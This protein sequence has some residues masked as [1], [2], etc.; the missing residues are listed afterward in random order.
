MSKEEFFN[1]ISRYLL[2]AVIMLSPVFFVGQA[3]AA[4]LFFEASSLKIEPGSS[5]TVKA[6]VNTQN[7]FINNAEAVIHYPA[8]LLE[9]LSINST[10]TIFS[11]WVEAPAF[12]N[13]SGVLSFNGGV[14][15]PG[16]NGGA[17]QILSVVFKAKKA[18]T[19]SLYFSG[20][21][22]R[23]NDGLGTDVLSGQGSL[24]IKISDLSP[25][26]VEEKKE[27]SV[28]PIVVN[29]EPIKEVVVEK[30]LAPLPIFS[31]TNPDQNVWY[32]TK[33]V[34]LFWDLPSN[35]QGIQMIVGSKAEAV[36]NEKIDLANKQK[37]ITNLPEG[38]SFFNV[39]Y[40]SG[41]EWSP[42]A[43]YKMQID[44]TPPYSLFLETREAVNGQIPLVLKASD[45]TSGISDFQ[46]SFD[47]S[48]NI[49]VP[50]KDGLGEF[51]ATLS[52]GNHEV[53]MIAYDRAG[54]KT[55]YKT[56]INVNP[57]LAP[58]I[59]NYD[60]QVKKGD[61]II[62]QGTTPNKN[63][64]L[65]VT[66][67]SAG[68]KIDNYDIKGDEN[69]SF[70]FHSDPVMSSGVYELWV[71]IVGDNGVVGPASKKIGVLVQK[72]LSFLGLIKLYSVWLILLLLILAVIGWYKYFVLKSK[73]HKLEKRYK[74][75]GQEFI[76]R[77][78]KIVSNRYKKVDK[79][80]NR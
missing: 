59:K 1:R 26:V 64:N 27:E 29:P 75:G 71:T 68:G 56:A 62:V 8:D 9:A 67:K 43:S 42:V 40:K 52:P 51:L 58:E 30:G 72:P 2:L 50:V 31:V 24:D 61:T 47:G 41:G 38:I 69:G 5:V 16:F 63:A 11:L 73:Y 36:P 7:K 45:D 57:S 55:E 32:S 70:E 80:K 66:L 21:A 14:P 4:T 6:Y 35:A 76:S 18:G 65:R 22:I 44:S 39:R 33:G 49:K 74:L 77:N 20:A 13:S 12:S 17:G 46:I 48:S 25:L 34:A 10:P 60:Q 78:V 28:V 23:E 53:V 15:N 3:K 37:E 79:K 54:N 19:A